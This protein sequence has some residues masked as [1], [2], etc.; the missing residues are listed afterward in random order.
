M[1][2][3]G[4]DGVSEELC[5]CTKELRVWGISAFKFGQWSR[6][7]EEIV[8]FFV[9]LP[10]VITNEAEGLKLVRGR[11]GYRLEDCN[12]YKDTRHSQH[13][14]N[15][16]FVALKQKLSQFLPTLE[17]SVCN[18]TNQIACFDEPLKIL[19]DTSLLGHASYL[20]I[21][22]APITCMWKISA[23]SK[24]AGTLEPA[25][26]VSVSSKESWPYKQADL[27]SGL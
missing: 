27:T 21:W 18:W 9:G 12:R 22:V 6:P 13:F 8:S 25:W 20:F 24:V 19:G 14:R 11:T 5:L 1:K 23:E 7:T 16:S 2:I 26:K 17:H 4:C 3:K 15:G 10:E